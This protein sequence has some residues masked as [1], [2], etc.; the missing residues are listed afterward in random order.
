MVGAVLQRHGHVD[1]RKAERPAVERVLHA[2]FDRGEVLARH[3]AAMHRLGKGKAVASP[4]RF[5]VDDDIAEL[6]VAAR[7]L[8]VPAADRDRVLDRFAVGDERLLAF[9]VTP[10]RELSR[11]SAKR[12]CISP[13]PARRSSPVS[14]SWM[15]TSDGSSSTSLA[16]AAARRTSSLRSFTERAKICTGC[17]AGVRL[18]GGGRLLGVGETLARRDVVEAQEGCCIAGLG[19]PDLH[20]AR[21]DEARQPRDALFCT[22]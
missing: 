9:A 7:L 18:S 20:R 8:L 14:W 5:H 15:K 4:A 16:R 2:G 19:A 10:K 13:W 17:A 22:A 3:G 1:D 11:S 21:A 6:A 12:K